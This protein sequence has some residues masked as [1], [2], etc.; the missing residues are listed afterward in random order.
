MEKIVNNRRA[1]LHLTEQ[2]SR[3]MLSALFW[4]I[5]KR[6]KRIQKTDA[7]KKKKPLSFTA[8]FPVQKGWSED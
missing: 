4:L 3:V 6:P 5:N 2:N 8:R 7:K 1:Y